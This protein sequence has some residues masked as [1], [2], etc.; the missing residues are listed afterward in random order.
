LAV[1]GNI[2][3]LGQVFQ[4]PV[5][6]I[7]P[8]FQRNY[9]WEDSQI[10]SL[11]E[12]ISLGAESTSPHFIGSLI[13][14]IDPLEPQIA[15]VI[16]GQQRL[17]TIFMTVACLRDYV[18]HSP[19]GILE[20]EGAPSINVLDQLNRFLFSLDAESYK[21]QD[22]FEA[23]P[24]IADMFSDQILADPLPNRPPLPKKHHN[25]SLLL[26]SAHKRIKRW[27]SEEI[28]KQDDLR[29][30]QGLELLSSDEK[31]A[32]IL[33]VL[34][35][36]SQK[37]TILQI[38]TQDE[39]ESFDIFMSLNSTGKNLGPADL[40]KSHIFSKLTQNL[41]PVEKSRRNRE[42]TE[43]WQGVLENLDEGD[44]DQFLRH[45]LLANQ[46][47]ETVRG[48]DVF[49]RFKDLLDV[50]RAGYKGSEQQ[51]AQEHLER[52]IVASSIYQELLECSALN[53]FKGRR[54]LK[55]LLEISSSY[56]LFLLAVFHPEANLSEEDKETLTLK[57]E[58]FNMRWV[59]S[60]GNAQILENFY[61]QL[62]SH[63]REAREI[64]FIV[65]SIDQKMPQDDELK[66][67]FQA[68]APSSSQ[69]KLILFRIDQEIS[70]LESHYIPKDV[71]LDL[72]APPP[73]IQGFQDW[74]EKFFPQ[75]DENVEL[76]YAT[77]VSQWGNIA[78]V[79]KPLPLPSRGH[80]FQL[81]AQGSDDYVGYKDA[82]FA[83]TRNLA[84]LNDWSRSLIKDR[85]TWIGECVLKLWP[86]N[87]DSLPVKHFWPQPASE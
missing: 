49:P 69:T 20:R 80:S 68:E 15:Q 47:S 8:D 74:A 33:R 11:L 29:K 9:A 14:R 27:P 67:K 21:Q 66:P 87:E 1:A 36:L 52:V 44:I 38:T 12:D 51:L 41:A 10:D 64:S 32:W 83:T 50:K 30:E 26:R 54:A 22:R 40:V 82:Y 70:E 76:E 57:I 56:R 4:S 18:A 62:A 61:Q 24:M 65:Q 2:Q 39:A 81:K 86:A 53:S 28:K 55:A 17:T 35:V 46:A 7:V 60:G 59:L 79:K 31:L 23:H 3:V 72:I 13:V 37:I 42:L 43:R 75:D 63:V 77:T 16:D 34:N 6:F 73:P 48:K 84:E 85:N 25:Y 78:L 5:R 71:H 58:S 45:Y 19:T